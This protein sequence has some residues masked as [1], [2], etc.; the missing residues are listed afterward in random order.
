MRQSRL[1]SL[2]EGLAN[3]V[4]GLLLAVA[5]QVVVFPSSASKPRSGRTSGWR[6]SSPASHSRGASF[7][8][9]CSRVCG[10]EHARDDGGC[11]ARVRS[12]AQRPAL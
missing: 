4:V 10:D 3:V 1:M 2:V 7:S 12:L 11:R 6:W 8:G 5:T 9:D